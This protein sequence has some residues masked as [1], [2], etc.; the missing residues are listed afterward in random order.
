MSKRS[1]EANVKA[2]GSRR[3]GSN[4]VPKATKKI[5]ERRFEV[6]EN[7]G[8]FFAEYLI[9][10]RKANKHYSLDKRVPPKIQK[11]F[12]QELLDRGRANPLEI[13]ALIDFVHQQR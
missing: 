13:R 9:H 1:Q 11:L 5:D 12:A 2:K 6:W 3:P 7:E 10:D 4:A 8:S